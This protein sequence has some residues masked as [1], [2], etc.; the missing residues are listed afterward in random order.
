MFEET[1][2]LERLEE[3]GAGDSKK[4]PSWRKLNHPPELACEWKTC[5]ICPMQ[6]D[7]RRLCVWSARAEVT[8]QRLP[9][10]SI[11]GAPFLPSWL[12][13]QAVLKNMGGI[14]DSWEAARKQD[15]RRQE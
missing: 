7:V 14:L 1:G 10:W 4:R 2:A 8:E 9:S 15:T 13:F 11:H 3:P 6:C 12:C 5:E